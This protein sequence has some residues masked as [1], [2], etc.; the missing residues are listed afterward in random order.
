MVSAS[1]LRKAQDAILRMR[2]YDQKL[3]NILHHIGADPSVVNTPY[4]AKREEKN[5]LILVVTSNR[6]LCGGFNALVI[7]R[8]LKLIE[9]HKGSQITVLSIGK[10]AYDYFRNTEFNIRGTTLPRRLDE[11]WD[12][13]SYPR[14][15]AIAEKV[16]DAFE[17]KQ[18]DRVYFVYNRFKNAAMQILMTE[19]L[20]P[21]EL[22]E[23][24]K[25]KDHS[26]FIFEPDETTLL[27]ALIPRLIR[28]HFYKVLLDSF[29]AEH[30]AR[31]TAM[32]K[33]TENAEELLG[34]LH[35]YYNRA[36][37][38]AITTELTEIVSGANALEG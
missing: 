33:A 26:D 10:K 18:F 38:A 31:M 3:R 14:I 27:E 34:E 9:E 36:R 7:K 29:A 2:P 5:I 16:M 32:D 20:L 1:K 35:L 17:H 6:G 22:P 30:G 37:Q 15:A 28:T 23:L 19:Q 11:V 13:L 4:L 12:D 8:A 21:L 25:S 24:A